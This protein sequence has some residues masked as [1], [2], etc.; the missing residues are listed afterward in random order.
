MWSF[1]CAALCLAAPSCLTPCSP[2]DYSLPGSSVQGIDSP[3]KNDGVGCHFLLQG[4]FLTQGR[5]LCPALSGGFS[6]AESLG[7]PLLSY[8]SYLDG[9][10]S[11]HHH[12]SRKP[13]IRPT[14]AGFSSA[15][16]TIVSSKP[17]GRCAIVV[18]HDQLFFICCVISAW[19]SIG[20]IC[21]SCFY[22]QLDIMSI[23]PLVFWRISHQIYLQICIWTWT[24]GEWGGF[25]K[26][27]KHLQLLKIS[28]WVESIVIY[29]SQ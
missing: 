22:S 17:W 10:Y 5:N 20:C 13:N 7:S 28:Y 24:T 25:V 19:K 14:K 6:T 18:L 11:C 27:E 3:G 2:V 8:L 12:Q 26:G 4:I 16:L 9:D 23:R 15:F 1:R 21:L 29:C